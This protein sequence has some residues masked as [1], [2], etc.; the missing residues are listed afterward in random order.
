MGLLIE[1]QSVTDT[2]L[3]FDC[4]SSLADKSAGR[5][6]YEAAHIPNARFADLEQDLSSTPGPG[7]RH[8]LPA[9]D[10]FA[11]SLRRWGV[12]NHS[13]IVCYD[14]NNGAFA[15]RMWWMMRWLGHEDVAVL[16]GGLDAWQ[17]ASLP[18]T[19]EPTDIASPGSFQPG[20]ALTREVTAEELPSDNLILI[21]A[22]DR[23]RFLGEV[24]PID[25]IAGH[26]PGAICAPFSGNLEEGRF[27]TPE[28]LKARFE[29][30]GI[31]R[32][33]NNVCYCGSGVTAAHNILAM[34][35]AG[36]EEPALYPGSWS[37]WITDPH[38]PIATGNT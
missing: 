2:H 11:A 20:R 1:P 37:E 3:V 28:S 24:E 21:D 13:S 10:D 26:I 8:P 4:R 33:A 14:Q 36:Y 12:S 17:S 6:L 5:Q 15:A 16:N 18:L 22:R 7:G 27:R 35:L 29:S 25:P 31:A 30:A 19:D 32:S 34:L 38:R 9:K 23:P